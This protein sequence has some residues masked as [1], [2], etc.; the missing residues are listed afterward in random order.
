MAFDHLAA[1]ASSSADER[2]FS[3]AGNVINEERWHMLDD[4]AEA[5]QCLKS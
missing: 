2:V 4:L 5:L 1:P 3:K